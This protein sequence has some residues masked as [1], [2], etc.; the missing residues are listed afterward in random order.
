MAHAEDMHDSKEIRCR[1]LGHDLTFKYCRKESMDEPCARI[2]DCWFSRIGVLEYLNNQFGTKF[3]HEF[4]NR[5]RKGKLSSI[6]EMIDRHKGETK[7]DHEDKN[8]KYYHR[9]CYYGNFARSL[10]IPAG[11]NADKA[12]A[13]MEIGVLTL[14]LPKSEELKPKTIKIET[15]K[16]AKG[17]KT[18][19]KS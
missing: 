18:E 4:V 3:L 9:E 16:L 17:K 1:K 2:I 19:T 7:E 8:G 11:L 12:E 14:S 13:T 10:A 15:K 5:E 6:L